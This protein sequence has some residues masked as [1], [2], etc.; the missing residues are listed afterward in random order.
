M[1]NSA[2]IVPILQFFTNN[3]AAL[4]E[5]CQHHIDLTVFINDLPKITKYWLENPDQRFG[6]LLIN[7]Q[8]VPDGKY[9]NTEE[10]DWLVEKQYFTWDELHYWGRN[11]TKDNVKLDKTEWIRLKDLEK[12]HIENI[13][14]SN[15]VKML[16]K[17]YSDYFK[18]RLME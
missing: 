12:D 13:L 11:Y 5:F 14:K 10:V 9:W 6:Q 8:I 1:R 15:L 4:E 16:S 7:L 2:R 3:S 17:R 18:L